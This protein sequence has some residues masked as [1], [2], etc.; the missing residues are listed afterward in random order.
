ME[1]GRNSGLER[2]ETCRDFRPF[3]IIGLQKRF[4]NLYL[5]TLEMIW[6]QASGRGSARP[7]VHQLSLYKLA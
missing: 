1:V 3:S 4:F 7:V 6:L 2:V 5:Q